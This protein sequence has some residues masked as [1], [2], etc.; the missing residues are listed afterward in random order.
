MSSSRPAL[1]TRVETFPSSV[2]A[3]FGHFTKADYFEIE[4]PAAREPVNVSFS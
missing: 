3:S 2:V 1:N 4:D